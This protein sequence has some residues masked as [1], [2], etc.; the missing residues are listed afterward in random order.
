[1]GRLDGR[2]KN[3]P[4]GGGGGPGAE[5]SA[6]LLTL[7]IATGPESSRHGSSVA[8]R[9]GLKADGPVH[10]VIPSDLAHVIEAPAVRVLRLPSRQIRRSE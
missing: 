10:S 1:M 9:Y 8:D 7:G 4:V 3:Y 2:R 6:E 5:S